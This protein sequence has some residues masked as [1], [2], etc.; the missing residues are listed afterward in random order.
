MIG[1]KID[2]KKTPGR[3]KLRKKKFKLKEWLPVLDNMTI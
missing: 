1:L 3:S 2:K